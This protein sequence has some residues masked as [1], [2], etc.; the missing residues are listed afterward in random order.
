MHLVT[1]FIVAQPGWHWDPGQHP[2]GQLV[3]EAESG[4]PVGR[5]VKIELKTGARPGV[6][7]TAEVD[8]GAS[9]DT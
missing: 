8:D 9:I 3:F 6:L 1:L 2:P 5:V 7:L 4:R